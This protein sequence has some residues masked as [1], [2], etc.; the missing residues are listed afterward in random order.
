M[1]NSHLNRVPVLEWYVG[2][3]EARAFEAVAVALVGVV[4][5]CLSLSNIIILRMKNFN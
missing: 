1:S 4:A 3:G 5:S 2:G